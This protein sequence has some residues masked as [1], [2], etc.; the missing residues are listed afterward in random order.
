MN[1][2]NHNNQF[3]NIGQAGPGII[4]FKFYA[5]LLF[6]TLL[7]N[8]NNDKIF[9]I[10]ENTKIGIKKVRLFYRSYFLISLGFAAA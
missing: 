1:P 8:S 7:Y 2:N 10:F 6:L 4:L 5:D 3:C 9:F